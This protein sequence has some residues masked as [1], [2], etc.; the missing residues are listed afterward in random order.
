[1]QSYFFGFYFRQKLFLT[2][3][4]LSGTKP[5]LNSTKNIFFNNQPIT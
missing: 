5:L 4:V 3:Y 1:M 2:H